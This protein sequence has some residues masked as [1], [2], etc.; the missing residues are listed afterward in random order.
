MW[1]SIVAN[2]CKVGFLCHAG[3][4]NWLG[5]LVGGWLG[6]MLAAAVL[7]LA[8]ALI[9]AMVDMVDKVVNNFKRE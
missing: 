7:G 8:G 6:L 2:F 4:P 3:E 9:S 1:D 5:W